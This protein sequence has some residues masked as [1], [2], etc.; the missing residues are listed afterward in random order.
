MVHRFVAKKNTVIYKVNLRGLYCAVVLLLSDYKLY[1]EQL[2]HEA[3]G[4]QLA[5]A[6]IAYR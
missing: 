2:S 1:G 5:R 4:S 3:N 6:V